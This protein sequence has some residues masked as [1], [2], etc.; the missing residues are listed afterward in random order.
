VRAALRYV[1]EKGA[2]G[3]LNLEPVDGASGYGAARS[4]ARTPNSEI[5]NPYLADVVVEIL[6]KRP[7]EGLAV[8]LPMLAQLDPDSPWTR[9][10]RMV[11][12][13][14]AL[15][16]L[17]ASSPFYGEALKAAASFDALLADPVVQQRILAAMLQSDKET[18][19]AAMEMVVRRFLAQPALVPRARMALLAMEDDLRVT[20]YDALARNQF[21]PSFRGRPLTA[22]GPDS[23]RYYAS[24]RAE[25]ADPVNQPAIIESVAL[26]IREGSDS[27][28]SA[29]V[30]LLNR[31]R[32]MLDRPQVQLALAG[33]LSGDTEKN[34]RLKRLIASLLEG[35]DVSRSFENADL[36]RLLDYRFFVE[37]VQPI[38]GRPG[39][40]GKACAQCHASHAIFKLQP[41]DESG[42]FSDTASRDNYRYALSVVDVAQP[43]HSLILIK[44]TRPTDSAGDANNYL[45]THNGGQRW[46]GNESSTEYRTILEWIR[47][48]RLSA[49]RTSLH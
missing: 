11:G 43:E 38:L 47:G 44:P 20:L 34:V 39:V 45:A 35:R 21:K 3:V 4:P 46:T 18:K 23:V 22:Q 30:D 5:L 25:Q 8:V 26:S 40:D 33:R 13:V 14:R 37:R 36:A 42:R 24:E 29:A 16:D 31:R 6:E 12:G 49:E 28:R 19:R 32:E 9:E 2:R 48:S 1:F 41:P 7:P 15:M 10:P 27:A 17:P